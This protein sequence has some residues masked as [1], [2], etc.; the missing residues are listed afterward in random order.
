M[1]GERY[2]WMQGRNGLN[3]QRL[4]VRRCCS[5]TRGWIGIL[6]RKGNTGNKGCGG[7]KA[8]DAFARLDVALEDF[9]DGELDGVKVK[10]FFC[11]TPNRQDKTPSYTGGK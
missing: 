4:T 2:S 9:R 3:G 1:E 7:Q 10:F 5:P 6:F 11:C 8:S